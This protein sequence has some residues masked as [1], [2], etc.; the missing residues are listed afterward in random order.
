MAHKG[1]NTQKKDAKGR[2]IFEGPR[3]GQYVVTT[4]GKKAKPSIGRM[5]RKQLDEKA[6]ALS[7]KRIQLEQKAKNLSA[8]RQMLNNRETEFL[9]QEAA[10]AAR[11]EAEKTMKKLNEIVAKKAKNVKNV[12]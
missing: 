6:R 2:T 8:K 3:G 10:R 5:S 1:R 4:S 12:K 9:N 11:L 7:A